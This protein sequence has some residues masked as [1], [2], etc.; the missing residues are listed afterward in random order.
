VDRKKSSG[1]VCLTGTGPCDPN[2]TCNGTTNTCAAAY[3]PNLTACGDPDATACNAADSCDATGTCVDR[4]KSSAAVCRASG[5]ECDLP[6]TCTGTSATC[7]ADA[8][9]LNGIACTDDGNLCT[10]DQCNGTAATCQHPNK[11]AGSACGDGSDTPCT[12]PD[13]CDGAGTCAAN[14]AAN[15]TACGDQG[16]ECVVDDTCQSGA[17]QDSGFV[18]AGTACGVG[19]DTDCT[20]PD[21][22]SGFGQ[23]VA[24]HELNG[25][26]CGD[27]GVDCLVDDACQSGACQ[28]GGFDP[29]GTA[30]TDE[31]D[32]C[33]DDSCDGAGVCTHVYD[34]TNDPSCEGPTTTTT[35]TTTTSSTTTST[36]T[37]T[38]TPVSD[39]TPAPKT[40]CF[41][42]ERAQLQVKTDADPA[43]DQ[44]SWKWQRG[45]A[46]FQADLGNPATTTTYYLCIY[47]QTAATPA[48][49]G[50]VQVD[51]SAAWTSKDP[52]GFNYKDKLG[53]EDGVQKA[54][55]KT[56]AA[57]KTQAQV[58]AKG[59]N[60]P[61]LT[62]FG[63]GAYF[64]ADP[65]VV[66]Q[67]MTSEGQCWTTEFTSATTNTES[68]FKA[69]VQ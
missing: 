31:P 2:D 47:D 59:V 28:D 12:D 69:K 5:G 25:T 9:K 14:H 20:N 34:D 23:C 45:E 49:V 58:K 27:Q 30:C 22:C 65:S 39:C 64:D 55:L 4:K 7:P 1:T 61:T 68:Q 3:A 29:A 18:T 17:C 37:T 54:K 38:V 50:T 42:A 33:T 10:N 56:G 57:G 60:L 51:P 19:D 21:T 16:I 48:L 32:I 40:G 24:N 52:K 8:K 53:V 62:P 44:L 41:E 46:L 66:V 11:A 67:L 63:G 36:T 13:T 6:E 26:A 43:R 35:T 15:G